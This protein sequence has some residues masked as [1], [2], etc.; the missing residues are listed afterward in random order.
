M[1][2]RKSNG[3]GGGGAS[4][5]SA[6]T[7]LL[8]SSATEFSFSVPFIPVTQAAASASSSLLLSGGS[9]VGG[10]GA[11]GAGS[12]GAFPLLRS[13]S[14]GPVDW[15]PAA[16][17]ALSG[18]LGGPSRRGFPGPLKLA[19]GRRPFPSFACPGYWGTRCL[20]GMHLHW[21]TPPCYNRVGFWSPRRHLSC[22]QRKGLL[23]LQTVHPLSF[24]VL[25]R[26]S[27][28]SSPVISSSCQATCADDVAITSPEFGLSDHKLCQT[29]SCC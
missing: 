3:G 21:C 26:L 5:P 17:C 2:E 4:A 19:L 27:S 13:L 9:R 12:A 24:E 20:Q 10:P 8:F 18:G 6:G 11:G 29:R 15:R 22:L 28:P 23:P 25:P 14:T 1:A 7:N 16:G